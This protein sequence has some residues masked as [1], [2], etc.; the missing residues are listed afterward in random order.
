MAAI[1]D[2]D[3]ARVR[4]I[5]EVDSSIVN[6]RNAHWNVPLN[7]AISSDELEMVELMIELGADPHHANHGGHSMLDSAALSGRRE[8]A[9][10]L[11]SLG[12]RPTVHHLAAIGDLHALER[13]LE[14]TPALLGS[15]PAGGRWMMSALHAAASATNLE[16]VCFLLSAGAEVDCQDH[17]GHTPL[18]LAVEQSSDARIAVVETLIAHGADPTARAG[19]NGGT[20][21]HRAVVC[22]DARLAEV[23]LSNGASPNARDFSG[24]TPLHQAVT[25]NQKLVRLV[26]ARTPDLGVRS[27]ER[28]G[29]E[30]ALEYARRLKK[31]AV[32]ELLED[33]ALT[34]PR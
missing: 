32:V 19:Q 16:S 15:S 18:A 3:Y 4:A 31:P 20:A 9:H 25:K 7:H 27:R 12:V 17:N 13:L 30:T 33:A 2:L 23:L 6:A 11:I 29:H 34:G 1:E 10:Y 8:I 21:L 26:L 28:A 14:R 22:G 5:A 24:K